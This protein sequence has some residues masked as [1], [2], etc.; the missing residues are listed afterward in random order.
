LELED[1][2]VDAAVELRA[3]LMEPVRAGAPVSE[4]SARLA[5]AAREGDRPAFGEL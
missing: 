3:G 1:E 4:D 5:R 2:C